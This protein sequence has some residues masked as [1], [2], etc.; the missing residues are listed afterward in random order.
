MVTLDRELRHSLRRRGPSLSLFVRDAEG[1]DGLAVV[2]D[3]QPNQ[4]HLVDACEVHTRI[5]VTC[6]AAFG[7]VAIDAQV[8]V[9]RAARC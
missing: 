1:I 2:R 7:K 9:D 4:R 8:K 3:H 6:I 5:G